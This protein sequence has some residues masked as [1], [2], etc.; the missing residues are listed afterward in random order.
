VNWNSPLVKPSVPEL[1]LRQPAACDAARE[2]GGW[3]VPLFAPQ[4]ADIRH[5]FAD[6]SVLRAIPGWGWL[7][8]L[9]PAVRRAA[10]ADEHAVQQLEDAAEVP[11]EGLAPLVRT[12]ADYVVNE[13]EDPTA[14]D[15]VG[16]RIGDLAHEWGVRPF[17][18]VARVVVAGGI[19]SGFVR[20]QYDPADEWTW[21]ARRSVLHD[22]RVVLQASDAGAHL[23][24][25]SGADFPTRVLAELVRERRE[26]TLE[27]MVHELTD[28]PARLY[29]LRDRGRIGVGAWAD[30]AVF[31]PATGGA[32]PLETARDL[33]GGAARLRTASTGIHAV[34]VVG[35]IVIEGGAPTGDLPGQLLRSG[36]DSRTV[37]ASSGKLGRSRARG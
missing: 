7:F 2:R 33:P 6:G 13:V 36:R 31:D 10:L 32:G 28:V 19:G 18:A 3:I 22:P 20:R 27:A 26:F 21:E 12:W 17:A 30:L 16:R 25:I 37:H 8:E 9:D 34:V 15:L 23:D 24:M 4:N 29:G 35:G 11:T 5:G 1:S 14:A